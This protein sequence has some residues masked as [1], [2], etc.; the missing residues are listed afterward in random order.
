MMR[1]TPEAT[2]DIVLVG[3]GHT[4]ALVLRRW[5]M[6]PLP[7]VR[8]T[9]IN[10]GPTAPY[11]GML[12]G[13]VAGH[14]PR[15]ALEIDLVRL[16]RFAGARLILGAASALDP[17]RREIT[18]GDR[19]IGYD[20][21]SIDI[22]VTSAMP[23]LPGFAE[24]AVPAKP[25]EGLARRWAAF[26]DA[27]EAGHVA[28]RAA[29]IGGGVAGLEL[30]MAMAH[31]LRARGCDAEV[32]VIEAAPDLPAPGRAAPRLSAALDRQGVT[33]RLGAAA[34]E[35][36]AEGVV[37][38]GGETVAAGFVAGAAGAR[39]Q[40]WLA[41]TGLP[42]EAGY[43]RVGPDLRVEGREDILAAGDCAHLS[44][45]PRPKAGV[46]AVCAAPVLHDNLRAAVAGR[47]LRPYRP[48]RDYL[49]LI[50]LGEKAALAEKGGIAVEGHL[51]WRLKDRID[52]DFMEK[53]RDLPQM[54]PAPSPDSAEP[55]APLCA[56][57]GSKLAPAA[58]A[59][60]TAA[61]QQP[62]R[63]DV[64]TTPGDDAAVLRVG[65]ALQVVTTDH[66]RAFTEDPA[67]L[68]RIAAV[69]AMGDVWAMGARPQAAFATVI[70]PRMTERLQAR[71]LDEILTAA[72]ET[73]RA[74]GAELAGGHSTMGA[75]TTLGF[76]VTGLLDG[77]PVTLAGARPGDVLIL[78][79]PIGSGTLLAAE[80]RGEADGE[81]I[82]ALWH[83]MSRPQGAAAGLLR[84][85]HA[86][87]DVT[88]F[89]LAGHLMAICTASGVAAE[90]DPAAVPLYPGAE[91]LA[92]RGV[93]STLWEA[94]RAHAPVTGAEGPRG[95]LLHDPQTAGGL[96][97][98]LP[99]AEAAHLLPR[100]AEDGAAAHC[101]GR[102]TDGPP[103]IAC[104][105]GAAG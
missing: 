44:H 39:P 93:R 103:G 9:L 34:A 5:G 73:F 98:A 70:L 4:H 45:A 2:H 19:R 41:E 71:M 92:A 56:G 40:R 96:L 62:L 3:G 31:A 13:H 72:S 15:K 35:V 26:L 8:L 37:L 25:L 14:Y 67:L 21:A 49:K 53:L 61:L 7:A 77:A 12:P 11:S 42:T 60:A 104:V 10:P 101:I 32:T 16:A 91:A 36:T 80:M 52:R 33:L 64:L 78:T 48:Q 38:E 28:P 63:D 66:L 86:M 76:T 27:A 83:A 68:A 74:A 54:T 102:L 94:N 47:P 82:A 43:L 87:T 84:G 79:R 90:I 58:L 55:A 23:D 50:S 59:R 81:E 29:V 17:D 100:L 24:H 65:A 97:A 20:L 6:A 57:C 89:G 46:Y 69:H 95:A 18:V 51:L 105:P 30:S 85:A 88:G 99:E 75:E 1:A 22:G